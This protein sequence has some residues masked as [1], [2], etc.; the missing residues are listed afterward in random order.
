MA[1]VLARR[2]EI[3]LDSKR[4]KQT[5]VPGVLVDAEEFFGLVA[6][7][8]DKKDDEAMAIGDF[9]A[10]SNTH[11]IAVD[12]ISECFFRQKLNLTIINAHLKKYCEFVLRLNEP[13]DI[14]DEEFEIVRQL[15]T[16]LTV[17]K[18]KGDSETYRKRC[19]GEDDEDE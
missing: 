2:L 18:Q 1:G 13:R 14:T 4:I 3:I 8:I 11:L 10:S 16:F 5:D 15:Q 6:K 12:V 19:E 9:L 17:L 7:Y